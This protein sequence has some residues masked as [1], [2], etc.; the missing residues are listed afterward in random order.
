MND[1]DNAAVLSQRLRI[2]QIIALAI[3]SGAM[4]FL[5]IAVLMPPLGGRAADA[6][7]TLTWIALAG[8]PIQAL[9]ALLMPD[10]IARQQRRSLQG[11]PLQVGAGTFQVRLI[12]RLALLEGGVFFALIA[13]LV[14]RQ[15]PALAAAVVLMALMA[16][17]FPT[18][19][20]LE[21]WIN[22][23]GERE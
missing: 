12:I 20:R 1:L 17:S 11:T 22:E 3:V 21:T 10:R 6:E 18:R 13:Y 5:A 19:D 14:E 9:L 7:P 23:R 2:M 8:A 16:A 15:W 4:I